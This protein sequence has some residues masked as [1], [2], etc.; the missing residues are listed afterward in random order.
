MRRVSECTSLSIVPGASAQARMTMV[1]RGLGAVGSQLCRRWHR[2]RM[3][4]AER[5]GKM[6]T[7]LGKLGVE[8]DLWTSD[9]YS[10]CPTL[11]ISGAAFVF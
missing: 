7:A 6:L 9:A 2:G 4:G 5:S 3:N 10:H 11:G 1:G 8:P